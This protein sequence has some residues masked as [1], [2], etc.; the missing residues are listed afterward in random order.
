MW[1]RKEQGS[2]GMTD[3][4][5]VAAER[6]IKY[7]LISFVDLFGTMRAKLVPAATTTTTSLPR[8]VMRCGRPASAS[9]TRQSGRR[10]KAE[11]PV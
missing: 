3:L 10:A 6:G 11:P 9:S 2:E 1:G 7:F 5:K 4:A 8:R